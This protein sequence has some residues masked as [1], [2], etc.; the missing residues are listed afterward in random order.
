MPENLLFSKMRVL[1]RTVRNIPVKTHDLGFGLTLT[2]LLRQEQPCNNCT[3]TFA[4]SF[5][6][7]HFYF[8]KI[9]AQII[10]KAYC[11]SIKTHFY[12]LKI[13]TNLFRFSCF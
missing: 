10:I 7:L 3:S 9:K 2:V 6:E 13:Y 12:I 5:T 1:A 11:C 8:T 4:L